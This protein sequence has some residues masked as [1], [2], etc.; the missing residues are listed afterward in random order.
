MRFTPF[1]ICGA[2]SLSTWPLTEPTSD[3]IAP[4][5]SERRDLGCDRPARADRN[6]DDDEIGIL[7]GLGVGLDHLVRDA[8]FDH[9]PAR[10]LAARGR[11]DLARCAVFARR[12]RDRAADQP[13][14][15]QR[16]VVDD[17]DSPFFPINSASVSTTSRFASSVPMVMRR[18]FGR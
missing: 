15:D 17:R 6:A 5:L 10:C 1:G 11:H 13:D 4:G 7:H 2:M 14:A 12:T 3:T 9:A 16:E 8:E 18:A